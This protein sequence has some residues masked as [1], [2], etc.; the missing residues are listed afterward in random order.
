MEGVELDDIVII[1]PYRSLD[2]LKDGKKV[3]LTDKDKKAKPG[4]KPAEPKEQQAARDAKPEEKKDATADKKNEA[5]KS[6][7]EV[8]EKTAEARKTP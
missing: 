8:K 5:K 1:G 4:D 6:E 3:A 2:Q 7:S